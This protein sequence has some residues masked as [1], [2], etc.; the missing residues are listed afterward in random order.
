[1][2]DELVAAAFGFAFA[3]QDPSIA[4]MKPL[5]LLSLLALVSGCQAVS[6]GQHTA[7]GALQ[8]GTPEWRGQKFVQNRCAVCHSVG[9]GETSPMPAAPA[10]AAIANTPGLTRETLATWLSNHRNFPE[11]MYFEVP[12]EHIDEITAYLLTLRRPQPAS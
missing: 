11:E 2:R 12:A 3:P 7:E 10:F 5:F 1:M 6:P 4:G 8:A 9:Y